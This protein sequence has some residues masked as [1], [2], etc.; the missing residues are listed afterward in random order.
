MAD[1]HRKQNYL[2]VLKQA[3]PEL[4][5]AK[6]SVSVR[7]A[8]VPSLSRIVLLSDKTEPG[9]LLWGDM[10]AQVMSTNTLLPQL[11]ERES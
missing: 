8:R 5:E 4:I 2:Q 7:S 9:M 3:I 10:M 11:L 1:Q 6:G